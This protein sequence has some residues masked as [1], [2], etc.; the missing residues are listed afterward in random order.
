[1]NQAETDRPK[2]A[3]QPRGVWWWIRRWECVATGS[4]TCLRNVRR[5]VDQ[6]AALGEQYKRAARAHIEHCLIRAVDAGA[7]VRRCFGQCALVVALRSV[8]A[9]S[10]PPSASFDR[11]FACFGRDSVFGS[12]LRTCYR[13][14]S[15]SDL[16]RGYRIEVCP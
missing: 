9:P 7:D 8:R 13:G 3:V 16:N 14:R 2:V 15:I 6:L 10:S 1:M 4:S 11:Q 5:G 12:V